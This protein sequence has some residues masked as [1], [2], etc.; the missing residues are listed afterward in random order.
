MTMTTIRIL[1]CDMT[2]TCADAVTHVDHKG[3]VYCGAHGVARRASGIPCRKL[4]VREIA[5]L[6]AGNPISYRRSK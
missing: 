1:K 3:Y 2:A 6:V 5:A 4:L